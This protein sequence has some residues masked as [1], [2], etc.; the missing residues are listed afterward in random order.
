[1]NPWLM[2][3]LARKVRADAKLTRALCSTSF[4]TT[5]K[6]NSTPE[7]IWQKTFE[8]HALL[9]HLAGDWLALL[10]T[11]FAAMPLSYCQQ[12]FQG[13]LTK[14][15]RT[16]PWTWSFS[17]SLLLFLLMLPTNSPAVM[18][19]Y[20]LV[21][22]PL[23]VECSISPINTGLGTALRLQPPEDMEKW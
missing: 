10:C 23:R 12:G 1:M 18:A 8:L 4:D 11:D 3:S 2:I 15:V 21:R 16:N 7:N 19:R 17:C 13:N 22:M 20:A 14:M 6:L 5:S 9:H